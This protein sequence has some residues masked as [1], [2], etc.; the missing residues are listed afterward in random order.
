[1]DTTERRFESDIKSFLISSKGGY[2]KAA[3]I[4]GPAARRYSYLGNRR[5]PN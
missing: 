1:M 4:Y 2:T 5:N 3:D